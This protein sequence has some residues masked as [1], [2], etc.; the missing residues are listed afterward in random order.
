MLLLLDEVMNNLPGFYSSL[1]E[2]IN[3][4]E[5]TSQWMRIIDPRLFVP[6]L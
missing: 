5:T 1:L 6:P 4:K 3:M 2:S